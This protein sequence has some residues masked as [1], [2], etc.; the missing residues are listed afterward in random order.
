MYLKVGKRV[1]DLFFAFLALVTLFPFLVFTAVLVRYFDS[2]PVIFYQMRIGQN[3]K[4]F[5]L[6]KFR[7]LPIN[8]DNISSD[9]LGKIKIGLIGRFIRRT[10][11]DELPQLYNILKG[12]MSLVGPRPSLQNQHELISLRRANG[13]LLCRPGLTG[14]AQV[15]SFNGMTVAEKA[16]LDGTYAHS[17]TFINDLKII[18]RT[19]KYLIGPPPVY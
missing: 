9:K 3:G 8:T 14:L 19:F 16:E 5:E 15:E 6:Y 12:D 18:L 4:L 17:I 13:A 7:S 10:N 2:S 11:I 1:F